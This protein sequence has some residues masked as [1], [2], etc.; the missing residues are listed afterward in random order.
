MHENMMAY[1]TILRLCSAKVCKDV[2]AVEPHLLPINN[3]AFDLRSTVTSP[4]ARLDIKAGSL[5]SRGETALFDVRVTHVNSTC[6]QNISTE[7]IFV[8]HEK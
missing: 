4:E 6:N 7:S 1:G 8:E 5:W 3:E 2:E